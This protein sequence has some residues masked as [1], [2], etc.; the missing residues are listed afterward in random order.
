LYGMWVGDGF[1]AVV[2]DY[3]K[4]ALRGFIYASR[5]SRMTLLATGIT[6]LHMFIPSDCYIH[7]KAGGLL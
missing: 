2:M 7:P 4:M 5:I 1:G 3:R 6:V